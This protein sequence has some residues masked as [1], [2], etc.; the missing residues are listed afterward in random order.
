MLAGAPPPPQLAARMNIRNQRAAP[1][2]G[3]IEVR[4][5]KVV[6]LV[7][8][9]HQW[10]VYS[11]RLPTGRDYVHCN[12]VRAR[13]L[14]KR[15]GT[16]RGKHGDRLCRAS[17]LVPEIN[18]HVLQLRHYTHGVRIKKHNAVVVYICRN[19]GRQGFAVE[20]QSHFRTMQGLP[21]PDI[22]ATMVLLRVVIDVQI[23]GQQSD[24]KRARLYR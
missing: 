14:P 7:A 3:T 19:L 18:H 4:A 5:L 11:T 2:C 21:K 15:A 1:F 10:T 13:S 8:N 22:L 23:A 24:L 17:R 20:E 16:T 6:V 9:Q 12:K